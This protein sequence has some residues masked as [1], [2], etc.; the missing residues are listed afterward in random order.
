M[1]ITIFWTCV[2]LKLMLLAGVSAPVNA[3]IV[4]SPT[5][6][7]IYPWFDFDYLKE[8]NSRRD[9][10]REIYP[11]NLTIRTAADVE[12][13]RCAKRIKGNLTFDLD[14]KITVLVL[15]WLEAVE[16]KLTLEAGAYFN[17][18][19][20][21]KLKFVQGDIV[22]N[23]RGRSAHWW[24]P[25]LKTHN[26]E[27][28]VIAGVLNDLTGFTALEYVQKLYLRTHPNDIWGPFKFSGLNELTSAGNVEIKVRSGSAPNSFLPKLETINGNIDIN[29]RDSGLFGLDSVRH[30]NGRLEI[31]DSPYI[32]SLNHFSQLISLGSLKL[33]DNSGL[34]DVTGLMGVNFNANGYIRIVDNSYLGDCEAKQL[35]RDL[36]NNQNWNSF[37]GNNTYVYGN[38]YPNCN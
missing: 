32:S 9:E 21:P 34:N 20:L 10:R 30:V 31:G 33:E 1:K 22:F 13:F 26:G 5:P 27:I 25:A 7:I 28:E 36:R 14:N 6:I 11:A 24:M 19:K 18:A 2:V 8:C 12:K 29:V 16:G 15:P 23:N 38:G 35:V 3:Q 37:N 4:I 17:K